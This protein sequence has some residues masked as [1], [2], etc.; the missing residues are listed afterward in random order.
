VYIFRLPD[1][2]VEGVLQE[3]LDA[4]VLR[5]NVIEASNT[6]TTVHALHSHML[7][8]AQVYDAHRTLYALGAVRSLLL[9]S[10]R[11]FL[12]STA[13]TGLAHGSSRG[14]GKMDYLI[15]TLLQYLFS[16]INLKEIIR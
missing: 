1:R 15:V 13:S 8:Y 10:P 16:S 4:V 5:D 7:L 11:I 12:C 2:V 3:I 14:S 6:S 9:T